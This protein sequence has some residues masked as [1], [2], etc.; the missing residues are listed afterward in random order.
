M[1]APTTFHGFSRLPP[2]LRRKV[3][4]CYLADDKAGRHV[5][6]KKGSGIT[7]I[8]TIFPT[9]PL[10]SPLLRVSCEARLVFLKHFRS[11]FDVY[12]TRPRCIF[13]A[14]TVQGHTL[15]TVQ[16]NPPPS[17]LKLEER[18]AGVVWLNTATDI[19]VLGLDAIQGSAERSTEYRMLQQYHTK[20]VPKH[21]P[22][23]GYHVLELGPFYSPS[24]YRLYF[25]LRASRFLPHLVAHLHTARYIDIHSGCQCRQDPC[26]W[27]D[28]EDI[29]WAAA[30]TPREFKRAI[31]QTKACVR[32]EWLKGSGENG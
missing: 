9:K 21:P 24:S 7:V 10:S 18:H 19:F 14:K 12:K 6:V 20:R 11:G 15:K 1:V 30:E 28:W 13:T 3:W 29:R 5:V 16:T 2:E 22:Q 23:Q 31:A 27:E 8:G 26:R 17:G 32:T 4:E 25:A